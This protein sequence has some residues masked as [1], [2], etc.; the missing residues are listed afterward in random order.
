[1]ERK[2]LKIASVKLVMYL[3]IKTV[4]NVILPA[5]PAMEFHNIP[6]YHVTFKKKG[7]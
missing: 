1:M 4:K 2:A 5:I 3:I 7:F 6:A